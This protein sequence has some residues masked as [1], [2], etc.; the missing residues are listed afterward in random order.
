[1]SETVVIISDLHLGQGDDF[2]I[3]TGPDKSKAFVDFMRFTGQR[4]GC[5]S[6][7]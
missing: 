3:F 5:R 1:M 7:H 2:D 4:E 6:R